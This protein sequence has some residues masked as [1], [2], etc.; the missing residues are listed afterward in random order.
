MN[1]EQI[2]ALY[3]PAFTPEAQASKEQQ[4][5]QTMHNMHAGPGGF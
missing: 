4:Q 3:A 1:G 2:R 5:Q